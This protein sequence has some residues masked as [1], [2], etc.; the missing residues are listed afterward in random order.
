M[1]LINFFIGLAESKEDD[2]N[3]DS[4]RIGYLE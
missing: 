1:S 2:K 3:M 4:K